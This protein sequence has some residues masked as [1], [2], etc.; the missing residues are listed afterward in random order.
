MTN[1]KVRCRPTRATIV[2]K[3]ITFILIRCKS[4]LV[5]TLFLQLLPDQ[6]HDDDK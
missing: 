1:N 5:S 3:L 4:H 6:C 2:H